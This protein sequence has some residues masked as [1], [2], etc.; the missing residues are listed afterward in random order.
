MHNRRQLIEKFRE[1]GPR[2]VL[3]DRSSQ[4]G[5][6]ESP[7]VGHVS[8]SADFG[9]AT[10]P[11][12]KIVRSPMV[13]SFVHKSPSVVLVHYSSEEKQPEIA[14]G[15]VSSSSGVKRKTAEESDRAPP[16]QRQRGEYDACRG[17]EGSTGC[18]E[19]DVS[20]RQP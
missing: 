3:L 12:L 16:E 6:C 20:V 15:K 11:P 19:S 4:K 1:T 10:S 7:S 9:G 13:S 5:N 17:C 2:K 18:A 8:A 14:A